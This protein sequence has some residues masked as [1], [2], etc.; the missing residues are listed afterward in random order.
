MTSN[1][2]QGTGRSRALPPRAPKPDPAR[3]H[4]L[5]PAPRPSQVAMQLRFE[6]AVDDDEPPGS[7]DG[8][9][10]GAQSTTEQPVV[11]EDAYAGSGGFEVL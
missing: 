2:L 1:D 6:Q 9:A 10:G 3:M 11:I 7:A 8:V 4:V 5:T